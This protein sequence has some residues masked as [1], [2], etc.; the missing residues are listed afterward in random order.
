MW[1][2][3]KHESMDSDKQLLNF[4]KHKPH[5][6]LIVYGSKAEVDSMLQ[7]ASDDLIRAIST[8]ARHMKPKAADFR[9][10][11][12]VASRNAAIRTKRRLVSSQQGRGFLGD[13][14]KVALP[15]IASAR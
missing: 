14:A 1:N 6:E 7:N 11:Q 10:W 12:K 5:F 8:G 4:V 15:L 9:R 3:Y 2:S 13:V